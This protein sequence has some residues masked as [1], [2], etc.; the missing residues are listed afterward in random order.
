MFFFSQFEDPPEYKYNPNPQVA[1]QPACASPND[2]AQALSRD[3][4]AQRAWWQINLDLLEVR[5]K[6]VEEKKELERK[7]RTELRRAMES[8]SVLGAGYTNYTFLH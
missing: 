2:R 7:L 5:K 8:P 1:Y 3:R 4:R 6:I